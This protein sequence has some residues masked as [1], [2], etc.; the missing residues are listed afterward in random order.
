MGLITKFGAS[1]Y[2]PKE[3]LKFNNKIKIDYLQIPIN[4]FDTRF[5]RS[6]LIKRLKNKGTKI[7]ARS[8]FLQGILSFNKNPPKSIA[9]SKLV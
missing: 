8:C 6:K 3:I 1:I 7:F 4:V 5:L 9:E 2:E